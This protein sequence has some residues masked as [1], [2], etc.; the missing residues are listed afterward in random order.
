[1]SVYRTIGPLVA[2]LCLIRSKI[3]ERQVMDLKGCMI[4]CYCGLVS[5]P[6]PK[7]HGEL[8]V[9]Q[10]SRRLCVCLAVCLCVNIF[11]LE[12]L[13][14]QWANCNEILSEP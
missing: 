8:I 10:S 4:F 11:K 5:S 9:Y 7:A 1:M 12:Y 2:G 3:T 14:N 6:E 13:R